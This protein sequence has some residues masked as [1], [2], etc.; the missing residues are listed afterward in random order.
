V[1]HSINGGSGEGGPVDLVTFQHVCSSNETI[2]SMF[3]GGPGQM[4]RITDRYDTTLN[5]SLTGNSGELEYQGVSGGLLGLTLDNVNANG[6][7]TF[8]NS[9]ANI[10]LGPNN[11]N[12]A[13]ALTTAG[14]TGVTVTNNITTTPGAFTCTS[15]TWQ[16][17]IGEM[18]LATSTA[19][20]LQSLTTAAPGAYTLKG[21]VIPA[22]AWPSTKESFFL[23]ETGTQGN[24]AAAVEFLDNGSPISGCTTVTL[25]HGDEFASC[26]LSGVAAGTHN[27][28][29]EYNQSGTDTHYPTG[30]TWGNPGTGNVLTVQVN[31]GAANVADSPTVTI[32]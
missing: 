28:T 9:Q 18:W 3:I 22:T 21:T 19:D 15:S 12:F 8:S 30:F 25:I 31:G 20:N 4:T 11:V 32:P 27:Y 13:G 2:T 5:G 7:V 1:G 26:T 17:L 24:P 29:M 23:N 14:G 16:P 10:S 6:T